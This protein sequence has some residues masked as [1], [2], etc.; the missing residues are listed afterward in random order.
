[1]K[2][3]IKAGKGV[4]TKTE[5]DSPLFPPSSIIPP[6]ALKWYSFFEKA[7][8]KKELVRQAL[9]NYK[10]PV[11][12]A[13]VEH[14]PS[15]KELKSYEKQLK[16][17]KI[18][19]L[20]SVLVLREYKLKLDVLDRLKSINK[21]KFAVVT[22]FNDNKTT[23]TGVCHC[24]SRSFSRGGMRYIIMSE[25]SIYDPE[26]RMSHFYYY[27]NSP[28]PIVFEKGELP[29]GQPDGKLLD[30]TIEMSVLEALANINIS[31]TIN[32]VLIIS[33][34]IFLSLSIFTF[35]TYLPPLPAQLI[36]TVA[37]YPI[38]YTP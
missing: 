15:E 19:E 27:A 38:Y 33:I 13:G 5:A 12:S 32:L 7:R 21:K 36:P 37:N 29:E 22:I 26:F 35:I 31:K 30:A 23:D 25:R 24:Y 14:A 16:T 20:E 10:K 4:I 3:K 1:M 8:V 2:S 11:K 9:E 18:A 28:F 6:T 17:L 34:F